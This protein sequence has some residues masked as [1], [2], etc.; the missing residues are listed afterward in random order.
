MSIKR[1][2]VVDDS[3]TARVVLRRLLENHGL[4][5]ETAESAEQALDYL[6]GKWPDVIFMDHTMPGMD[7]LQAVKII[8]NDPKT[9][10]IPV[11]MYTAKEGEVY[12]GQARALGAVGVLPKHVEAAEL[13]KV[14]QRLGLVTDRR[15]VGRRGTS[16]P[17]T[18]ESE[19]ERPRDDEPTGIQ[20]K[21]LVERL[22]SEQRHELRT[23]FLASH[24]VLARQVAQ[25]VIA[26]Q[27]A[28]QARIDA[29]REAATDNREAEPSQ[30]RPDKAARQ[31]DPIPVAAAHTPPR[32]G[33]SGGW[34]W[35]SLVL[36]AGVAWLLWSDSRSALEIERLE[37]QVAAQRTEM[38]ARLADSSAL[39]QDRIGDQQTHLAAARDQILLMLETLEWATN[40]D[41]VIA[42]SEEALGGSRLEM[43]EGLLQRLD[44]L[45]FRGVL[46]LETHLGRFCLEGDAVQGYTLASPELAVD[47]C[48]LLGH[49]LDD[50]RST[51]GRESLQFTNFIDSSAILEKGDIEM[52]I[53]HHGRDD[54]RELLSYPRSGGFAQE[55]NA[56]AARNNRLEISLLP[57]PGWP[58][59]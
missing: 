59:P 13:F 4:D 45:A 26:E 21:S 40:Q 16:P 51:A 43:I 38:E 35:L 36:L 44:S 34:V 32:A 9:A 52:L 28:E 1:A 47:Q 22:L 18:P 20:L 25:E 46:R 14:L 10:M 12:V 49:P 37:Q 58:L 48:A 15:R 33:A 54:S 3:Q 27:R 7:G 23:D 41:N 2:L 56:V 53:I 39:S 11:M 8:K 5:V 29:A 55:W 30:E 19:E 17:A 24:R 31:L 50:S 6:Q 57:A 42:F